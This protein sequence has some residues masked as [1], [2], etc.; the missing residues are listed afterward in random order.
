MMT[1]S[2]AR[3]R[4]AIHRR[5]IGFAT[6]IGLAWLSAAGQ[7]AEPIKIGMSMALTGALA[8]TGKAALLATQMA[9]EDINAKGG[10]LGRPLQL[11]CYDDQSNPSTVPGI[12]TKLLDVDKVDLVTSGYATNM[13]A[14]AMPIVVQ[15]G[16]L[17]VALYAL[18]VN[19]QFH[20]DRYFA[21][22]PQGTN[23]RLEFSEGY[24]AIALSMQPKP[25]SVAI[26]GAD[27]EFSRIATDGAREN[28]QKLGLKIVYDKSYPPNTV[29]FAPIVRAI[30]ATNP[31]IVYLASYPLDSAGMVRAVNEVG[32]KT[33]MFGGGLIGLQYAAVKQQLGPLLNGIT[34]FDTYVPEPT[35]QFPG[36]KEFLTRYQSRAASEGADPLGF[37]TP[38][39]AYAR[40][41]VM[42]QAI[43]A[44]K[45]LEQKL[46]ADYLHQTM[47]HTIAGD[48]RFGPTGEQPDSRVL[49][50]QYQEIEGN[51]VEQFKLPG[52][53]VILYPPALKSGEFNYPFSDIKR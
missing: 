49:L 21:I 28:A 22:V 53:Q 24:Y 17:F 34:S 37:Y 19:D 46:L 32:L 31:D 1:K 16:L 7:A 5:W 27:A 3:G 20:Y 4:P 11:I 42:A 47:F 44:T 29:D 30:Q 18:A 10:L 45:S 26:A 41:Q 13:V 33:K 51:G 48:M 43:E 9:V 39:F 52:K 38:P 36:I 40:M 23:A 50:V 35:L 12:Y 8:G 6:V 14:P 2:S 25:T 15:R